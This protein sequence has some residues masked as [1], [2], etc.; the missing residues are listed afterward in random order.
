M[1]LLLPALFS[2]TITA[3][4]LQ[5]PTVV[6]R[7]RYRGVQIAVSSGPQRVYVHDALPRGETRGFKMLTGQDR[8]NTPR[9]TR[10]AIG[11]VLLCQIPDNGTC[12]EIRTPLALPAI[13][14]R[15]RRQGTH[16]EAEPRSRTLAGSRQAENAPGKAAKKCLRN[17][18]LPPSVLAPR[19]GTRPIRTYR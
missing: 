8:K 3:S 13:P 2:P 19:V 15:V 6:F 4:G 9:S 10:T 18:P 16:Q 7:L 17:I 5:R 1:T 14:R 12:A 11:R